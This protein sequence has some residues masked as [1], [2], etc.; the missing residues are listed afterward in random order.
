[1]CVCVCYSEKSA[2]RTVRALNGWQQTWKQSKT[3]TPHSNERTNPV[4]GSHVRFAYDG[5]IPARDAWE[6]SVP[7][8]STYTFIDSDL[9]SEQSTE[10]TR[11]SIFDSKYSA[12]LQRECNSLATWNYCIMASNFP[13]SY[14]HDTVIFNVSLYVCVHGVANSLA[15]R[16]S[17]ASTPQIP[18]FSRMQSCLTFIGMYT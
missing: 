14:S 2:R 17:A 4:R 5:E 10:H 3:T 6:I 1:M 18:Y 12:F 11:H 8:S 13:R 7:P 9:P 15:T 16:R